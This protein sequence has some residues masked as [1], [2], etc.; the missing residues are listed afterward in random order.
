MAI[1]LGDEFDN[2]LIGSSPLGG[3]DSIYG[4]GG[5]DSLTGAF[6]D[7]LLD[8]GTGADAMSGGAGDDT[9]LV[10]DLGDTVFEDFATGDAAGGEDEV[11]ASI[12]FTLPGGVENLELADDA[13]SIDGTG[14]AGAN[15]V[16]GNPGDN[17]LAGL[18]G[19]DT[20]D[21][22]DG[23]DTLDG[24]SGADAL[25]GGAGD[26]LYLVDHAG[27]AVNPDTAG[28]DT[29]VATVSFAL[30][31]NDVERLTLVG[32]AAVQGTGNTLANTLTGSRADNRL[33]G[34]AG[35]DTLFGGVGNDTLDGGTGA[36][37]LVGGDQNDTYRVDSAGD[38]VVEEYDDAYSG[39]DTVE[40]GLST[41]LGFGLEKLTLTG[42]IGLWGTGNA[43]ANLLTGNTGANQLDGAA[44]NDTLDG[45][46]GSDTL[47]GGTGHD[48]LVGGSGA[49]SLVGG[50]GNDTYVVDATGDRIA[51]TSTLAGEFDLVLSSVS[52][53]LGANL[54]KLTLTGSAANGTG[55]GLANTIAGNAAANRLDGAAGND[56]ID[57]SGGNDTVLGGDGLDRLLGG[58]GNDSLAGGAG[59]D[60]LAGGDGNDT[61]DGG[62][63]IDT[64]VGGAGDDTFVVDVGADVI[65]FSSTSGG[66]I[67][68]VRSAVSWTLNPNLERLQLTGSAAFGRGNTLANTITGNALANSLYGEEGN[69][70]LDGAG[71]NDLLIGDAGRDVFRFATALSS[72]TNVDRIGGFVAADDTIQLE[73]AIFT[74]LTA[75]GTLAA[76][77]FARGSG[78]LEMDDRIVYDAATGR[79]WYDIDG[80]GP[81]AKLLFATL[82]GGPPLSAAD[83][84][85]T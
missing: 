63:G 69:D 39:T 62:T 74:R 46:A 12:T 30:G 44:G 7:D 64:L 54:E 75:T 66:G 53:T 45:G 9:Y 23:N 25:S 31:E 57:G 35:P 37:R 77:A 27:D 78:A 42:S 61:L 56:T 41:T 15:A 79:I 70:T 82:I 22:G 8:G 73:N 71:G 18:G 83:F 28:D 60:N 40:A 47:L 38:Q 33:A 13:G 81:A 72:S 17:R 55:N 4:F 10:D 16:H 85:V 19:S 48:S 2:A 11:R 29:V 51:E 34:G 20:L 3:S 6:G 49:D 59:T 67:D 50:T 43:K 24:G 21:G 26:D 80:T 58:T 68:T 36:D 32:L 52:W 84:V 1:I 14:N 65:D 76:T 5:N